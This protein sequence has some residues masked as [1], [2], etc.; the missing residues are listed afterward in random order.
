M[1][2]P[3][4][5]IAA[6]LAVAFNSGFAQPEL[7]QWGSLR[8]LR[9]EGHLHAFA[10]RMEVV[11]PDGTV[12][13][14]TAHYANASRYRREGAGQRVEVE[15]R[16]E[17]AVIAVEETGPCAARL[18]VAMTAAPENGSDQGVLTVDLP[19][20][21]F[22]GGRLTWLDA[23]GGVVGEEA[24]ADTAG[25]QE[26]SA[27]GV[28]LTGV[29][30]T[31]EIRGRGDVPLRVTRM[32]ADSEN[33]VRVSVPVRPAGTAQASRTFQLQV[34]GEPDRRPV[35]IAVEPARPG[36]RFDG[37]GGNFRLQF[38]ESDPAI[39]DY[40]LANLRVSWGRIALWW[41]DWDADEAADPLAAARAG[42]VTP[43][44][45]AQME[46]ARRLAQRGIPVIVS[47]WD[48]PA[49]AQLTGP[50][51][52]HT[53]N[54][55]V[56]PAKW[57]R[58]AESIA[59]YLQ[60]LKEGYGVEAVMFSFNEPDLG[61]MP[62]PADHAAFIKILGR[63]CLARGL[64]TKHL[65][66]DTSNATAK[67]LGFAQAVINDIETRPFIG[68]V[69]FHSWGG[70]DDENLVQWG[71]AARQ[72]GVPLL[73]SEGGP[74]AE[75]HRHPDLFLEPAYALDEIEL[76]VRIAALAQ[77][78]SLMHWQLTADYTLLKGGG[79]YGHAGPLAHT[80][81]FHAFQQLGATPP[82]AFALPVTKDR[83]DVTV[84][85][86][87][88]RANGRYALHLVNTGAART[89]LVSG[90]PD[91]VKVLRVVATATAT[92]LQPEVTVAV[93]G[94]RAEIPLVAA[95]LTSAFG[96]TVP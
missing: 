65:V 69:G 39:I 22:L 96:E 63:A 77:P 1:H 8:G 68:A 11:R 53:Y 15:L 85:A 7:A 93:A 28:R 55:P 71:A 60:F 50:R 82:G 75:A 92:G 66:A 21:D 3:R 34:G 42:R 56:N 86:F 31:W 2:A 37:I 94:G 62:A 26:R 35:A 32:P 45:H 13:A 80:P 5:L 10:A 79:A 70:C 49:W 29:G 74:D 27:A 88:D 67:S 40:K 59:A 84:A 91:G 20:A 64:A 47:V 9:I 87:G 25:I 4:W 78:A 36:A 51:P 58:M 19:R 18:D 30:R 38:P 89:A 73:L 14:R 90:L 43:R 44:Q 46:M 81:R 95:G 33:V 54:D 83:R 6:S 76:Y 52:P 23:I 48:P 61:L 16:G 24:V 12:A 57:A 72:L 17:K 41:R